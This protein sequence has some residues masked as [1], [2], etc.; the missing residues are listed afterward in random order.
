MKLKPPVKAGV[1][2]A[3]APL[4]ELKSPRPGWSYCPRRGIW[5]IYAPHT[6]AQT[7]GQVPRADVVPV[8]MDGF[9]EPI[10]NPALR[11]HAWVVRANAWA[12]F[13]WQEADSLV[14]AMIA[15]EAALAAVVKASR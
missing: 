5:R 8:P 10:G 9:D 12:T 3:F 1:L 6:W 15:A 14:A 13:E 7:M 4:P 11:G 2:G